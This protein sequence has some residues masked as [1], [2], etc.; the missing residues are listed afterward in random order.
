M[1]KVWLLGGILAAMLL[2][3]GWPEAALAQYK[4]SSFGLDAG[5]M[6]ITQP[7]ITDTAGNQLD[8]NHMPIRLG[9]GIRL[10]GETNF[11]LHADHWWFSA[12]LDASIL[13]FSS[14]STGS[15]AATFDQQADD[16]LGTILGIDGV[17]G[18]RYY[19]A[20]D[21]FRPYVQLG[22][23]YMHMFVFSSS[24]GAA[25]DNSTGFCPDGQSNIDTFLPHT[26]VFGLHLTPGVEL[27]LSRDLALNV[28]FDYQR[29]VVINAD[30]NN[31]FNVGLGLTF[32]G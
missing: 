9:R 8:V 24:G 30:D 18:V 32:Y 2:G 6:L 15:L 3:V 26:N 13:N 20:T 14:G 28:I 23:S 7:P 11:K 29:W 25:C 17:A 21:H 10:G 4:N 19:I 27:I 5:Y 12:R 22:V 1:Q 31:V 16:T